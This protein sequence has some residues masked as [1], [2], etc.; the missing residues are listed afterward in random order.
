MGY[1]YQSVYL[2]GVFRYKSDWVIVN[3]RLPAIRQ[4]K[5]IAMK[6]EG[7]DE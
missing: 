6:V 3:T 7:S 5:T 4:C 2:V 1:L